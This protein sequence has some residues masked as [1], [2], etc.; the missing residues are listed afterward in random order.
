[1]Q[2]LTL[3]V[4]GRLNVTHLRFNIWK[5]SFASQRYYRFNVLDKSLSLLQWDWHRKYSN[6]SPKET[7]HVEDE[8]YQTILLMGNNLDRNALS[9]YS[10]LSQH[11]LKSLHYFNSNSEI[12]MQ[13]YEYIVKSLKYIW[14]NIYGI[15]YWM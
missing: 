6:R 12:D 13:V 10:S 4:Q 2:R 14:Y 3:G 9:C 1:M 7:Q 8:W 11:L 5:T 15:H